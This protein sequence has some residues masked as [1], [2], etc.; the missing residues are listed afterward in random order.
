[1]NFDTIKNQFT[2]GVAEDVLHDDESTNKIKE[3]LKSYKL[4]DDNKKTKFSINFDGIKTSKTPNPTP[5]QQNPAKIPLVINNT[6]NN[7][8]KFKTDISSNT[9]ASDKQFKF[10]PEII[11]NPAMGLQRDFEIR[12][13]IK[14]LFSNQFKA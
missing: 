3:L 7:G 10:K 6:P 4:A 11:Q 9:L 12:E 14:K 1:M 13:K 5:I 2:S 8:I